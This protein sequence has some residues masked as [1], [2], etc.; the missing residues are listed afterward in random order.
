MI[1]PDDNIHDAMEK[2]SASKQHLARLAVSKFHNRALG[3]ASSFTPGRGSVPKALEAKMREVAYGKVKRPKS[4][5]A[6]ARQYLRENPLAG[7][8]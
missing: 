4:H 8:K 1:Y 2:I 7:I 3:P 5:V 6:A